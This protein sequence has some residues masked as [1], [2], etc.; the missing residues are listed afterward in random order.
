MRQRLHVVKVIDMKAMWAARSVIVSVAASV[1][2]ACEGP[3]RIQGV[4]LIV[5]LDGPSSFEAIRADMLG[6]VEEYGFQ[7]SDRSDSVRPQLDAMGGPPLVDRNDD[8]IF[9]NLRTSDNKVLLMASN[10]TLFP[11]EVGVTIFPEFSPALQPDFDDY[12]EQRLAQFGSVHRAPYG[13][14]YQAGFCAEQ[15]EAEAER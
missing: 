13:E 4:S 8:D 10:L 3:G 7:L 15:R 2:V 5:C 12:M 6:L 9:M 11:D 1:L 14:T